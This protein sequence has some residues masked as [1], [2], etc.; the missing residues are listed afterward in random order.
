LSF[1][2]ASLSTRLAE[3]FGRRNA[4]IGTLCLAAVATVLLHAMTPTPRVVMA[5]YVLSGLVGAVLSPQFWLLA[6][7]MFTSA[8]G[9]RLFGPIAS[10]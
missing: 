3:R 1:V 2:V 7:Q 6:A 10:G 9:R 5:L 4:L 8:Q